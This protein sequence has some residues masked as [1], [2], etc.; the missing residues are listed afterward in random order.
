M[1]R[2]VFALLAFT[3]L[4]IA[5]ILSAPVAKTGADAT[6]YRPIKITSSM[7]YGWWQILGITNVDSSPVVIKAIDSSNSKQNILYFGSAINTAN[8]GPYTGGGVIDGA[9]PASIHQNLNCNIVLQPGQ[10]LY[11]SYVPYGPS[12]SYIPPYPPDLCGWK[13]DKTYDALYWNSF[14]GTAYA[15][16]VVYYTLGSPAQEDSTA[17][18][19]NSMSVSNVPLTCY[20]YRFRCST[21][22]QCQSRYRPELTGVC[23][24]SGMCQMIYH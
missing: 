10:T 6:Y 2:T 11:F 24:P 22:Q 19:I 23:T 9:C 18:A 5:V 12:I 3:A 17:P 1:L 21:T 4:S 8:F 7:G 16:V 15:N 14:R 20:D 13:Y